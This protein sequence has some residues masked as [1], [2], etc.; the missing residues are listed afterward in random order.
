MPGYG[1]QMHDTEEILNGIE[2][3]Y[4]K[5]IIFVIKGKINAHDQVVFSKL[6]QYNPII[7]RTFSEG[8]NESELKSVTEDIGK[9]LNK[10]IKVSF[11]SNRT[12]MNLE[13]LKNRLEID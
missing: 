4:F 11:V 2:F 8:L 10:F 3:R 7:V 1:T 9:N 5:K 6:I 13:I 12:N